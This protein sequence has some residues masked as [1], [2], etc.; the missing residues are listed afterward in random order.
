[1][2]ESL[3]MTSCSFYS[4]DE[5]IAENAHLKYLTGFL[6]VAIVILLSSIAW[7]ILYFNGTYEAVENENED[8][9][10]LRPTVPVSSGFVLNV[11]LIKLLIFKNGYSHV[12]DSL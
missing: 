1:M 5:E 9:K 2:L 3:I 7:L 6:T 11:I 10:E 8:K 12:G 4:R